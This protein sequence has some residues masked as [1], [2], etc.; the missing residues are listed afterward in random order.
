MKR[1]LPLLALVAVLFTACPDPRVA[2]NFDTDPRILRGSWDF[3]LRDPVSYALISTQTVVF[4]ANFVDDRQYTVT[5]S[6]T[7]EGEVFALTGGVYGRDLRFVRPQTTPAPDG[8]IKLIGMV[9]AKNY[10]GNLLGAFQSNGRWTFLGDL[11]TVEN[12]VTTSH[13]LEIIRN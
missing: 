11:S 4:T 9:S 8:G 10:A 13:R 6:V 1:L 7:L 5:A 12:G 2:V 3:V